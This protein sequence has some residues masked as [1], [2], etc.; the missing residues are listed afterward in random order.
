L[1]FSKGLADYVRAIKYFIG[2]ENLTRSA[3]LSATPPKR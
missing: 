3:A 2:G 1:S